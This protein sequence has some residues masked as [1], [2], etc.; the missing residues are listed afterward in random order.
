M[1]TPSPQSS[2]SL[3]ASVPLAAPPLASEHSSEH[4]AHLHVFLD[5]KPVSGHRLPARCIV[6]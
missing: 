3:D 6:R 2:G 4:R 5:K 1:N